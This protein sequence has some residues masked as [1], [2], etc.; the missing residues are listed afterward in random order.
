MNPETAVTFT[1]NHFNQVIF[2]VI[3]MSIVVYYANIYVVQSICN[4]LEIKEL[5]CY[6]AKI[7]NLAVTGSQTQDTSGVGEA[8]KIMVGP[9]ISA[10]WT[11]MHVYAYCII[12]MVHLHKTHGRRG[13]KIQAN[14]GQAIAGAAGAAPPAL[15]LWLEPPVLCHWATTARQTPT[16]TLLYVHCTGGT[17]MP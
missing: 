15:H 4:T 7:K 1:R 9:V 17:E 12:Y 13:Y 8:E 3:H 11:L 6:E 14:T 2:A 5:R 10:F 16:L